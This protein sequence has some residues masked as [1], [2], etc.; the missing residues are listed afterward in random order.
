[1]VR[2][3]AA[4]RAR[5][6][7]PRGPRNGVTPPHYDG[8]A[9]RVGGSTSP[10]SV[11]AT[12]VSAASASADADSRPVTRRVVRDLAQ[13]RTY[14]VATARDAAQLLAHVET[15][16]QL[17]ERVFMVGARPGGVAGAGKWA[18]NAPLPPRWRHGAHYL[19]STHPVFHFERDDGARV[20]VL[21][22]AAWFG[23]GDY[24]ARA[25]FDAYGL[26][27]ELI[28]AQF[29]GASML[30][31]PATTGRELIARTLPADYSAPVLGDVAQ[32]LIRATS[33]Q[34][35]TTHDSELR[36]RAERHPTLPRLTMLDCR[37]AYA[38]LCWGLPAGEPTSCLGIAEADVDVM[39][40]AHWRVAVTVPRDW[41]ERCE[42]GAPGHAGIGLLGA[43]ASTDDEWSYPS[44]PG[45][46][47]TTWASGAEVK[48]ARD[49]GWR[50]DVLDGLVWA[51]SK[52]RPLDTWAR[53]LVAARAACELRV[54]VDA[55]V[56]G[57][58][59]GALRLML[60]ASIGALLGA[61]REVT[62]ALPRARAA[63]LP[64]FAVPKRAGDLL[65]WSE[66]GGS[67][68]PAMSR[69]EWSAY[70]YGRCRARLL[71]GPTSTR[72]VRAGALHVPA[73]E[74][75]AM[76]TDAL[77]LA[78]PPPAW[79]DDGRV[80]LFVLKADVTGPLTAPTCADELR[81]LAGVV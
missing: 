42:C 19:A 70:I 34:G 1:M 13:R 77:Y 45:A 47:F 12:G 10:V 71:D 18:F 68:W 17:P 53:H 24:G 48:V 15:R 74:V 50:V 52:A 7:A 16:A 41:C 25:A 72:G 40:R 28:G 30:T 55:E 20:E 76:R 63:E 26:V 8:G 31:T 38:A 21:R 60:L 5:T 80:G 64:A 66:P 22:G 51:T 65:I 46:T 69:P 56:R 32:E 73:G 9:G 58:A 27:R 14:W 57:M 29:P 67:A 6:R 59:R 79:P 54:D 61:P 43:R 33:G 39:A 35:R 75:L 81:A 4:E 2:R 49:H 78:G 36:E 3:T 44:A 23:E 37:F 11:G 62:R